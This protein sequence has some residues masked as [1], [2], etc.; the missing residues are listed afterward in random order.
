MADGVDFPLRTFRSPESS[1]LCT[2]PMTLTKLW[3]RSQF[4]KNKVYIFDDEIVHVLKN[5]EK[6]KKEQEGTILLHNWFNQTPKFSTFWCMSLMLIFYA[7]FI[8]WSL[9]CIKFVSWCF[10]MASCEILAFPML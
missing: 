7:F 6:K 5:L 3:A 8:Y 1:A 2:E 9:Y 10:H 4:L